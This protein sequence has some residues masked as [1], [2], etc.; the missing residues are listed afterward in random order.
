M[1]TITVQRNNK[2]GNLKEFMN[3]AKQEFNYL[4]QIIDTENSHKL[5]L[6]QNNSNCR[7]GDIIT[8]KDNRVLLGFICLYL[9]I[10][11]QRKVL[12]HIQ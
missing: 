11:Y 6:D 10:S 8:Y 1:T 3:I 2:S 7:Y 4:R 12:C 9:I 5:R